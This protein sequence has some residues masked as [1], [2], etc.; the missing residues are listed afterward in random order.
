MVPE[1][2]HTVDTTDVFE[3]VSL[4]TIDVVESV[5][6]PNGEAAQDVELKAFGGDSVE[7]SLLS[8]YADHTARLI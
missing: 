6:P 7:L 8:L 1:A 2:H 4:P 5:P 3:L